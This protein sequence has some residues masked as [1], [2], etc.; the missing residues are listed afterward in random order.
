[1]KKFIAIAAATAAFGFVN[2]ASAA[3]IPAKAYK[4]PLVSVYNW[5]GFYIGGNAGYAWGNSDL[6]ITPTNGIFA[7]SGFALT[8]A[9]ILANQPTNVRPNGFTGGLQIGYNWQ[10]SNWLVGLEADANYLG[11]RKSFSSGPTLTAGG[12][13]VPADG[14]ISTDFL[15][16]L[17]P[18]VGLLFDR[19]LVYATGGLAVADVKFSENINVLNSGVGNGTFVGSSSKVRAGW[20]AG[21]GV[22]WALSGRWRAKAEY[23]YVD[24]GSFDTVS[25]LTGFTTPF[26]ASNGSAF[27]INSSL[28]TSIARVGLNYTY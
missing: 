27:T 21:G 1:V 14:K 3:D 18:R 7:A 11:L 23:L 4:A 20:T 15:F 26:P 19:W 28:K 25:S 6:S 12:T 22:E 8:Q 2:A 13:L 9:G 10:M 24:L 5:N 16:T 17:R